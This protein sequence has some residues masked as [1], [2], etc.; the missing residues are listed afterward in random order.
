MARLMPSFLGG[1]LL[2]MKKDELSKAN[3]YMY[4]SDDLVPFV[5]VKFIMKNGKVK[6]KMVNLF[7]EG[8]KADTLD[9]LIDN[10]INY[11]NDEI[12]NTWG[13]DIQTFNP[14]VATKNIKLIRGVK[15]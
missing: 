8:I 10:A 1:E 12:D 5:C 2:A 6:G 14:V 13:K 4:L 3:F 7:Y 15:Q 11:L 9:D